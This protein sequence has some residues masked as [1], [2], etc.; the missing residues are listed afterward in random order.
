MNPKTSKPQTVKPKRLQQRDHC[1]DARELAMERSRMYMLC[2]RMCY[3][4][5]VLPPSNCYAVS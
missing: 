3:Q 2:G 4:R 1:L 5:L